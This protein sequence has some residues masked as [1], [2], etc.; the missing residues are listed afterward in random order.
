MTERS[1]KATPP[2]PP[3]AFPPSQGKLLQPLARQRGSSFYNL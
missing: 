3:G 1:L 2:P